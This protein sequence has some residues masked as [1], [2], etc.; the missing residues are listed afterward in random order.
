MKFSLEFKK[1][2]FTSIFLLLLLFLA[3][4]FNFILIFLL[5]ITLNYAIIEFTLLIKK[6]FFYRKIIQFFLNI[7]FTVYIFVLGTLF[8][9]LTTNI[10][11]K[12]VLFYIILISIFSDIGGY[13][14]GKLFK[15][16]KLT[17][18][19][20]NKTIFGSLGSFIL[21]LLLFYLF[22]KDSF[23]FN[24]TLNNLMII[25][26]VS[27]VT[28]IGD[29]FFS[30]LKRKSKTKDTGKILPGHGGILDRIDGIILGIPSGIIFLIIISQ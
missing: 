22:V 29:I 18:I 20:P 15:G 12:L 10:F 6:I 16:P 21:P 25:F 7:I 26:I 23:I 13:I 1:R 19:S 2:A 8:V 24:D 27:F 11:S 30:Y 5:I 3:Y 17:K 9:I 4:Q 14:F 28:Q